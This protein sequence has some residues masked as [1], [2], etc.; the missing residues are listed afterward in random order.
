M[1]LL[2]AG[3]RS[4]S[5]STYNFRAIPELHPVIRVELGGGITGEIGWGPARS[6]RSAVRSGLVQCSFDR[7][8]GPARGRPVVLELHGR[9]QCQPGGDNLE[10]CLIDVELGG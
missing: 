4:N 6:P 8:A 2:G 3:T 9:V 7:A 1:T 10:Q 5:A